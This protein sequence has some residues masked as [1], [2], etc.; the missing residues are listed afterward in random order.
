MAH[1]VWRD[2]IHRRIAAPDWPVLR[3]SCFDYWKWSCAVCGK[4]WRLTKGNWL[5]CHHLHYQT[6]WHEDYKTDLRPL[7]NM[8]HPKGKFTL[9]MIRSASSSYRRRKR[10]MWILK[11]LWSAFPALYRISSVGIAYIMAKARKMIGHA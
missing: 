11:T 7:C 8:H 9:A 1:S 6:L 5:E 4:D 3:A 10:L 2:E